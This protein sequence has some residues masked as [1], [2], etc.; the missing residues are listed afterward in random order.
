MAGIQ[1]RLA[2]V[3]ESQTDALLLELD[4]L[5]C[6][7]LLPPLFSYSGLDL[8]WAEAHLSPKSWLIQSLEIKHLG[9][10]L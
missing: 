3:S 5:S 7:F 2:S 4:W 6:P 8:S 1:G 10:V 9:T